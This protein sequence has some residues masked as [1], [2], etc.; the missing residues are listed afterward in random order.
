MGAWLLS[1]KDTMMGFMGVT[2]SAS[3]ASSRQDT[4][5]NHY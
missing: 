2:Y 5:L 1:P 3:P 4:A